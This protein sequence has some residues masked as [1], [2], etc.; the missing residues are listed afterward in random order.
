[1]R[2]CQALAR[3]HRWAWKAD[4][5]SFFPSV[6]HTVLEA[7]LARKVKDPDVLRL[8][9]RIIDH[10]AAPADEPAWFPGDDLFAPAQRRRGRAMPDQA[11]ALAWIGWSITS[12]CW[13]S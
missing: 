12:R 7:L 8:A 3:R 9:G 11:S 10:G 6:D 2:R 13:R 5:R 4:V 1:M